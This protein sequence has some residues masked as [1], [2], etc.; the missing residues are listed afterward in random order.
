MKELTR[1]LL[2]LSILV[3]VAMFSALLINISIEKIFNIDL[4]LINTVNETKTFINN[5]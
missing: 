3:I 4:S 5:I 2:I 1:T